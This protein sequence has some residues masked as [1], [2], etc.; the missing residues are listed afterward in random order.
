MQQKQGQPR[1]ATLHHHIKK[2]QGCQQ[3]SLCFK[4]YLTRVNFF[5]VTPLEVL[6]V[7]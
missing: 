1:V 2:T 6:M 5:V 3:A 7:R 4:H